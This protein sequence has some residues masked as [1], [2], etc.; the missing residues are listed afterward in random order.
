MSEMENELDYFVAAEDLDH[1]KFEGLQER[2]Y[3][4]SVKIIHEQTRLPKM[5]IMKLVYEAIVMWQ[6]ATRTKLAAVRF[7]TP[8]HQLK[9]MK[10]VTQFFKDRAL[11]MKRNLGMAAK[12][13]IA[14]NEVLKHFREYYMDQDFFY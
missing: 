3:E 9:M 8:A 12:I 6:K 11:Q 2:I 13:D 14:L 5:V 7:F 1:V 10:E 4:D